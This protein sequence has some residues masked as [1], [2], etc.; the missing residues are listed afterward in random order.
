MLVAVG[1]RNASRNASRNG[2][3]CRAPAPS[4]RSPPHQDS[5]RLPANQSPRPD[6]FVGQGRRQGSR[7]RQSSRGLNG[8]LPRWSPTPFPGLAVTDSTLPSPPPPSPPLLHSSASPP[9]S[10]I[11]SSST[12]D[13]ITRHPFLIAPQNRLSSRRYT[14]VPC[15]APT[16]PSSTL[17]DTTPAKTPPLP[18]FPPVTS[19]PLANF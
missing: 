7:R 3:L 2:L 8:L 10:D 17:L 12:L 19:L 14:L 1:S 4:S 6:P 11:E 16:F 15:L 13:S 9:P 5:S 18:W